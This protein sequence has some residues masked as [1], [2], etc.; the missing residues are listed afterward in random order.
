[1]ALPEQMTPVLT[2]ELVYTGITRAK[3]KLDLF[4][5]PQILAKAIQQKTL[6]SSGLKDR[7]I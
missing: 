2:R 5:L 6:R 1:M 3:N 7:L 4:A